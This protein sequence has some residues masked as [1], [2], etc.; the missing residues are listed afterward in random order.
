MDNQPLLSDLRLFHAAVRR[1]SFVATAA[2]LGVSPAFVSKRIAILEK[3]LGV[4]LFK[5]TTRRVAITED[6]EAVHLWAGKIIEA[7][8]GLS[9]SLRGARAAP[10]GMLRITADPV[11]GREHLAPLLAEF[12]GCHPAV[13]IN[14]QLGDRP[15]DRLADGID[16][17]IRVGD[18]GDSQPVALRLA[19]F[20]R[21]VCAAPAYL[22]RHGDPLSPSD[23]AQHDCLAL[24]EGGQRF[25]VWRLQGPA[26]GE[27]VKVSGPLSTDSA[28][29]ARSWA[30]AGLGLAL[31]AENDVAASLDAGTLVRLLPDYRQQADVWA[32]CCCAPADSAKISH[33]LRFLQQRLGEG[34]F[35]E[36]AA[37]R[38][39]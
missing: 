4:T 17:D 39:D 1:S 38:S 24:R 33:C 2:E 9:E 8:D 10:R 23:L 13:E 29:V 12:S 30:L 25:G 37:A 19:E 16:I 35:V 6:G 18:F 15:V 21:I 27:T 11:F 28:D 26:G 5:R 20:R 32:V 7:A 14:L 31:L 34:R 36:R 22:E 3:T